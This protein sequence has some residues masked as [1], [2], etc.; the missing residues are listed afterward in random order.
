MLLWWVTLLTCRHG[1]YGFGLVATHHRLDRVSRRY[2]SLDY[3]YIPP[4]ASS[5]QD[6]LVVG[7]WLSLP[8]SYP[9][10]TP[11]GL[12]GE[13]IRSALRSRHSCVGWAGGF[14]AG[15]VQIQGPGTR[16]FLNNKLTQTFPLT[17]KNNVDTTT[18]NYYCYYTEACLLTPRGRVVDR[19]GVAWN[20]AS[21]Q[22]EDGWAILIPSRGHTARALFDRLN[23]FIFPLDQIQLTCLD[24][25]AAAD[26]NS[27]P[28]CHSFSLA[29][30]NR[31]N[32]QTCWEE[33]ICPALR[34]RG[35]L[36]SA[37]H[38]PLPESNQCLKI[39]FAHDDASSF[40]LV[41]PNSGL[42][43]HA[44][45]GYTLFFLGAMAPWGNEIWNDLCHNDESNV[46]VAGARELESLRIESGQPAFGYEMTGALEK[47]DTTDSSP[48]KTTTPASPLELH[49]MDTTVRLDKGCYLGQEGVAS[50]YKNPRGP[51]RT[52][53][54]VVFPDDDNL[55]EHQSRG[56]RRSSAALDNDTRVPVRGDTLYAL[57][58][59]E[60]I[61]VG[62]LTSVA[63]PSSTGESAIRALALVR[64]ADSIIKQM[65]TLGLELG[66][67]TSP[68]T[69]TT[70]DVFDNNNNNNNNPD[71]GIHFPPPLKDPLDG[72]EVIVGGT[73]TVGRLETVPIR[74]RP[75]SNSMF[76]DDEVSKFVEN[77]PD[78]NND[79]LDISYQ[80]TED[81]PMVTEMTAAAKAKDDAA[82]AQRKAEKLKLLQK[83]AEEALARRKQK[84]N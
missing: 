53:Y 78:A 77:L 17:T 68:E 54:Q 75:K 12:R 45:A 39:P 11:A 51:P 61:L 2:G 26:K 43:A 38:W 14:D 66:M 19:L 33:W 81:A 42:P 58:S 72:L 40:L 15:V 3:E 6:M 27:S 71:T 41:V 37:D 32:V 1:I 18:E 60:Q 7:D 79:I 35:A 25:N 80:T 23:P 44:G 16:D 52:L 13:A 65:H 47:E 73:F 70:E 9:D 84:K 28:A 83:R 29:A 36:P 82:E 5:N 64:R 24:N 63:E 30:V 76:G 57:G 46:V 56:E 69:A 34:K 4:T 62:T 8:S 50:Q 67:T 55:Y 10:D 22:N 48:T 74:R 59:N 49:L 21:Q 20:F 31:H